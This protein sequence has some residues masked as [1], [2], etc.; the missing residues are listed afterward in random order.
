MSLKDEPG[1]LEPG[2]CDTT[3]GF[4]TRG[5]RADPCTIDADCDAPALS[6]RLI[7]RWNP[8]APVDVFA[9]SLRG[10]PFKKLDVSALFEPRT[11]GCARKVDLEVSTSRRLVV[12]AYSTELGMKDIDRFKFL[13]P[14]N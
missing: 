4:C 10:K 1:C 5:L 14:K 3:W 12:K 2:Q 8:A 13:V 9:A 11:P 6:C 7:A